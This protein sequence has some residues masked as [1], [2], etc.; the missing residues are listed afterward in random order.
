[1]SAID[2]LRNGSQPQKKGYVNGVRTNR[3]KGT[4]KAVSIS[5]VKEAVADPV[6][7][8]SK[9]E[10]SPAGY[11]EDILNTDDP[12]SMFMEHLAEKRKEASEW[13][14]E[15]QAI[16]EENKF[17]DENDEDTKPTKNPVEILSKSGFEVEDDTDD[18]SVNNT[19]FNPDD[20]VSM[21]L[22]DDELEITEED[23]A[24]EEVVNNEEE[25]VEEEEVVEKVVEEEKPKKKVTVPPQ[26]K[27]ESYTADINIE[28]NVSDEPTPVEDITE[29]DDE[30]ER[31]IEKEQEERFKKLQEIV[32][33]RLKPASLGLDLSSFTVVQKAEEDIKEI[34]NDHKSRVVKWVAMNQGAVIYMREFSGSELELMME[35]YNSF[36]NTLRMYQ[37]AAARDVRNAF[38]VDTRS[39]RQMFKMVYDHL[40]GSKPANF[41]TWMRVT[42]YSDVDDYFFAIY[43]AS[44]L[45][46]NFI[47]VDCTNPDC[48]ESYVTE[49]M[50][51]MKTMV[52][53]PTKEVKEKFTKIYNST[54]QVATSGLYK[55]EVIPLTNSVA[56][57]F[58]EPSIEDFITIYEIDNDTAAE[59]R[60]IIPLLSYIDRP[61][62]INTATKQLVPI[63]HKVFADDTAKT[64]RFKIRKYDSI[65]KAIGPDAFSPIKAY[66]GAITDKISREIDYVNPETTCPVCG[67]VNPEVHIPEGEVADMVFTRCQLGALVNTSIS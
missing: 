11:I 1:M 16:A 37:R 25:I 19:G 36:S 5:K 31:D 39:A 22:P 7:E 34:L 12:N 23:I 64:L 18:Y 44:F 38:P 26:P 55:T 59:Y 8:D 3:S 43:L 32:A 45:G 66:I 10:G 2:D 57:G 61:Y 52:K 48:E 27:K 67:Q 28:S 47:P 58:K 20:V 41:G 17:L 21:E 24:E 29:E 33:S 14:A 9:P 42:P 62:K 56:F 13:I 40:E 30:E 54:N 15:Q 51:I 4:R 53:F 6:E 35:Y 49:D 50:D 65:F 46:V 63:K 60:H